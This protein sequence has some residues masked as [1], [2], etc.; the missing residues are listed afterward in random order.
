MK[1]FAKTAFAV[2]FVLASVTTFAQKAQKFGHIN[3]ADLLEIMPEIKTTD[4]KLQSYQTQLT[5]QNDAMVNEYKAK[6][7][8]FQKG[9]ATMPE[10]KKE[11][12]IQ[13]LQDLEER[14]TT[15]QQGA[16]EKL[17]AKKQELYAPILDK[18]KKAIQDVAKENGYSYVFDTSLGLLIHV[19]ESDDLMALVKKKLGL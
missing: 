12:M 3:S 8:E 7:D 14:I 9:Q 19:P 15:F 6:L 10:V 13:E 18:A 2:L 17:E 11:V 16:P 4:A 5:E 1:L